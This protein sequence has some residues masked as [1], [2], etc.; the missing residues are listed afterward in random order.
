MLQQP[1]TPERGRSWI[2]HAPDPVLKQ[3][4]QQAGVAAL[5]DR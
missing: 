1:V 4:G 3:P 5:A 2:L